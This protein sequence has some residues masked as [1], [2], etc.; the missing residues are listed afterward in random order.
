[1]KVSYIASGTTVSGRITEL[2]DDV[3]STYVYDFKT[4]EPEDK[5]LGRRFCA[6]C[7]TQIMPDDRRCPNCN[8]SVR[9]LVDDV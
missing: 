4:D 2:I 9:Q 1:M 6:F 5:W 7:D 3:P 8:G